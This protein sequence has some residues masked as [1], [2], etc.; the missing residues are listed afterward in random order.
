MGREG[1][2]I[3]APSIVDPFHA[4]IWPIKSQ[5]NVVKYLAS[6]KNIY[7][8]IIDVAMALQVTKLNSIPAGYTAIMKLQDLIFEQR[9][10]DIV[11]DVMLLLQVRN[12]TECESPG[13]VA[14][15]GLVLSCLRPS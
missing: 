3:C 7:L 13:F 9:K 8:W 6:E 2:S 12:T 1:S 5:K 10:S 11:E 14:G 4:L 15:W